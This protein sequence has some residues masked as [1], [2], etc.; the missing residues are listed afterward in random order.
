MKYFADNGVVV[1]QI[2]QLAKH[3]YVFFLDRSW[4]EKLRGEVLPYP[5]TYPG[6]KGNEDRRPANGTAL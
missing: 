1:T 6:R 3:R 5:K 2:K 4:R